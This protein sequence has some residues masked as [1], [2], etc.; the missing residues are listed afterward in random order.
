MIERF[1]K[2]STKQKI[3]KL[4][5]GR[6]YTV[7][8]LVGVLGLSNQIIHRHLKDLYNDGE[9]GKKGKMPRVFYFRKNIQQSRILE[10]R[11]FFQDKLW[12]KFST[13]RKGKK[14]LDLE[15][16]SRKNKKIDFNFLLTASV[17]YSSNIEG[18]TLDLN[19]FLN[20][21]VLSK[22]KKKEIGEIE[23]LRETYV[24][25][26]GK[27]IS[28]KTFLEA[29]RILSK[30][31][32]SKNRQGKY[33]REAVGVFGSSGLAYLAIES[34]LVVNE[35]SLLF[36][37]VAKLLEEKMTK[38]ETFFWAIWLH[39]MLNLIH[40]FSDGNGRASRMLEKWFLAEKVG[41]DF[42]YLQTEKYYW[43]NLEKYYAN[44]SL[45]ANYWE[46][47]FKNAKSFLGI[48]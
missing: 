46:V 18:N 2:M 23:D 13:K 20:K 26:Q 30:S 32:V 19:S 33:R 7:A 35:M 22:Q 38:T 37:Q 5:D 29:H 17:L 42:W 11:E 31:L 12:P 15:L 44:L 28:E 16:P 21:E 34:D 4:L 10:S 1:M 40:P 36:E 14:F 41:K 8:E 3:L 45:G 25:A 9:V 47:D 24:Y 27:K 48:K 6:D 39:L 43:D